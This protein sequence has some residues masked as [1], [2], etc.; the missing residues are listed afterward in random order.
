MRAKVPL[1][2]FPFLNRLETPISV[3]YLGGSFSQLST[4]KQLGFAGI[5]FGSCLSLDFFFDFPL[6]S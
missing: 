2:V 6:Q 1:V 4:L 5:S 3:Q